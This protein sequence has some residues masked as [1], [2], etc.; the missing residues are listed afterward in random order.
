MNDIETPKRE[1]GSYFL[2]KL[3]NCFKTKAE[4]QKFLKENPEQAKEF[5]IVH[6]KKREAAIRQTTSVSIA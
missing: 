2:A 1:R 6:G 4:L 5:A 3:E